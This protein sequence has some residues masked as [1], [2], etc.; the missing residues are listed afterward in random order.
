MDSNGCSATAAAIISQPNVLITSAIASANVSCNG[1]SN[2]TVSA[3]P[4]GGTSPYTYAWS[5]GG[6]NSTK[7]GLTPGTYTVTV[8]DKNGCTG[9]ATAAITQPAALSIAQGSLPAAIGNCNGSAWVTASGGTP[10]YTYKWNPSGATTDTITGQCAGSY[11][12]KVTDKNGCVDSICLTILT[13]IQELSNA[14]S[15]KIYPDPNTGTFTVSGLLREQVIE[16][17]N[18][19]G[20]KL[21]S[22]V[23]DNAT[24]H[25]NIAA[26]ANGV[27]LVRILNK[28]GS[29]VTQKKMVK[30]Q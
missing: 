10:A 22:T 29:V 8:T 13:G 19:V 4:S 24:M 30:T 15:I 23:V 28:D 20:Q 26:N 25:F 6:T 9:T 18:Y 12:C 21:S 17:Y 1:E 11:C 27:Y 7:T 5:G 14:S 2:G 16:L 3:T